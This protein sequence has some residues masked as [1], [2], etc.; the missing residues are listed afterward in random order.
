VGDAYALIDAG[1]GR[2]L[3]RFRDRV[4]DRP[5]PA[6]TFARRAA[7]RWADATARFDR[8]PA[9]SGGERRSPAGWT[10]RAAGDPWTIELLGLAFELRF[11]SG[12]QVG[13][14]PE[15][16]TLGPW[17]AG[18]VAD[19]AASPG[20]PPA[21]LNLFAYTGALSLVAA[22]AGAAVAHVDASRPAVTWARRNA[23]LSGLADSPI[24]WLVDDAEAFVRREAA[25]GRRYDGVILD[26]PSY[27]HAG[28]RAWRLGDRLASLLEAAAALLA[29][30]AP[31]LLL[32]AHTRDLGPHRLA[33]R[34]AATVALP[35]GA[36]DA[37][38][39]ELTAES[40]AV[41]PLGAFAR[42]PP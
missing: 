12:G 16:L 27:G 9:V 6:A 11:A 18:R 7:E 25:R 23:A 20:A 1:E 4:V 41:L 34:L 17:V 21:V 32:T 2:R 24:R 37:G 33:E 5:A 29:G 28:R 14:F 40:G 31:F 36:V 15:H 35:V 30:P 8:V 39:L 3:E 38:G 22:R 10:T 13:L 26:P 19:S 42:W